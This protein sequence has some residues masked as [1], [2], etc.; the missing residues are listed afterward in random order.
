[1]YAVVGGVVGTL[2]ERVGEPFKSFPLNMMRYGE[3][4]LAG[5]KSLCGAVN[6]CTALIGLF[7]DEK[8]KEKRE[9]LIEELCLWY[10][11]TELP[12]FKPDNHASDEKMTTT[13]A[14]SLI[15]RD[16]ESKWCKAS[17]SKPASSEQ[18]ER[19]R[20]LTADCVMKTVEILNAELNG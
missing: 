14:D 20:R 17:G 16:S 15:C 12:K 5:Q 9:E 1:M 8:T 7:H 18:K 11:Q 10:K 13:I 4:G 3:R 6:G 2:A 19:C